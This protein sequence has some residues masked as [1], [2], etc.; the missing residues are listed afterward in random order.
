MAEYTLR[1]NQLQQLEETVDSS[2]DIDEDN[3]AKA[4]VTFLCKWELAVTRALQNVR[5]P[6]Y[7]ALIRKTVKISRE[8]AMMAKVVI[9]YEGILSENDQEDSVVKTYSVQGVAGA[10]PIESHPRFKEFAGSVP[11]GSAGTTSKGASYDEKGNF[12]NFAVQDLEADPPLDYYGDDPA[13]VLSGTKSYL[14]PSVTYKESVTYNK[15]ARGGGDLNLADLGKITQ[16]PSSALLPKTKGD[17]N[18]IL[19]SL[20]SGEVGDGLKIDR[21][22]RASGERGWNPTLYSK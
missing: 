7:P 20:S 11:R 2:I 21:E 8:E 9:G 3:Q 15:S 5:H 12:L 22:W 17:Q 6:E 18:W 1:G 10:E 4:S 19:V 14:A 16:P 13:K